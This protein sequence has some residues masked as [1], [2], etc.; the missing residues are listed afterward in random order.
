VPIYEYRAAG[1]ACCKLC[2]DR[3]E[4]RQRMNE[5]PLKSCPEC[6]ARVRKLISRP[7]LVRE[8]SLDEDGLLDRCARE[9]AGEM[10]LDEDFAGDDAWD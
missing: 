1:E 8:E 9:E 10:G 2:R 3:F 4:V 6:G 7:F 5:G